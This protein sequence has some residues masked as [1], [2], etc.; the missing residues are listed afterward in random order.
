[1][2]WFI[3]KVILF[4][5]FGT[6]SL[7]TI[8]M[9]NVDEYSYETQDGITLAMLFGEQETNMYPNLYDHTNTWNITGIS[10]CNYTNGGIAYDYMLVRYYI[11]LYRVCKII[12]SFC[13][14]KT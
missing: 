13:C 14:C 8:T 10:I 9:T 1:M 5:T 7:A 4:I 6:V 3:N 2:I 11:L 12:Q